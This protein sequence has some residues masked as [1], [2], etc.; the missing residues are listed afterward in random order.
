MSNKVLVALWIIALSVCL[1]A[2]NNAIVDA[3]TVGYGDIRQGDDQNCTDSEHC[4][5]PPSNPYNHGCV[6][7]DECR[8]G[9]PK[10]A[11]GRSVMAA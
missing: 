9:I 6:R 5:P 1:F 10:P 4:L 7:F 3:G 8:G 11:E 2:T